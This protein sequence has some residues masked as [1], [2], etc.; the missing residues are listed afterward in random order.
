VIRGEKNE[1]RMGKLRGREVEKLG[2][3]EVD[4]RYGAEKRYSKMS[5][6]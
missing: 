4:L 5:E 2:T 1:G 3:R 6:R